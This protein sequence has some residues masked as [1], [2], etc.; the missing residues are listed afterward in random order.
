MQFQN[1]N[2]VAWL[3]ALTLL[4]SYAEMILPRVVP[5]FRLGLGNAAILLALDLSP[6]SFLL[7]TI[8]KAIAS[9]LMSG[10]LFSPFFLISAGQ[11]ILSGITMLALFRLNHLCKE[12]LF[13]VYGI[14]LAGSF[15]SAVAQIFFTSLYLGSGTY[16]LLGPMILFNTVSGLVTAKLSTLITVPDLIVDL[17]GSFSEEKCEESSTK[18]FRIKNIVLV[19]V[20][21]MAAAG[22]FFIKNI[23]ILVGALVIAF[24]AQLLSRRKI[25]ILP[26]LWMWIFVIVS[27]LFLPLGKVLFTVGNLNIT[28]GALLSGLEKALKLSTVSALSQCAANLRPSENTLLGLALFYYRQLLDRFDNAEGNV[29]KRIKY[30]LGI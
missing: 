28:Q 1:K 24:G 5:F 10:T 30:S 17:E 3:T 21:L 27:C 22:V 18:S 6:A 26:H 12:K 20:L 23:W 14:S 13:S 16:A 11:S 4:L 9:S 19:T 7:L 15:V 25:R 2:R 8:L 29:L